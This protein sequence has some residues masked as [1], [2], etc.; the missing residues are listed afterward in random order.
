MFYDFQEHLFCREPFEG[1]LSKYIILTGQKQMHLSKSMKLQTLI[2]P[3]IPRGVFRTQWSIYECLLA[4]NY[5]HK[6][7]P[8]Q[9]F[10]WVLNT[11]L[12]PSIPL[13][14]FCVRIIQTSQFFFSTPE[15]SATPG[16]TW[17]IKSTYFYH[18]L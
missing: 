8:L 18:F 9:M 1:C 2:F 15:S 11:L 4:V 10:D 13:D 12:I 7:A 6:K 17:K 14:H 5:F 16:T 3:I